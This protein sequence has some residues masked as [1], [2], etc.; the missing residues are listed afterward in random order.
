[1]EWWWF[2]AVGVVVLAVWQWMKFR[3][4]AQQEQFVQI[5]RNHLFVF[6]KYLSSAEDFF[7]HKLNER[8]W[9]DPYLLGYSQGFLAILM[10]TARLRLST[11]EKGRFGQRVFQKLV[12]QESGVVLDRIWKLHSKEDADFLRGMGH[13]ADV[14]ALI[15]G[16]AGA[17]LLADPKVQKALRD[18]PASMELT[19]GIVEEA[20]LGQTGAAGMEL[21]QTYMREH[22]L[23]AGY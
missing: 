14:S 23:V 8:V 6:F 7:S 2:V 12:G 16:H 3:R 18:A 1:M 20:D 5:G 13:G 22:K 10:E 19:R 4:F 11:I 9:H 21:A 17:N 15:S